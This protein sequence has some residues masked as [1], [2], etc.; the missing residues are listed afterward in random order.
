MQDR[1]L[2]RD[3]LSDL[4]SVTDRRGAHLAKQGGAYEINRRRN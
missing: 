1:A 4:N 2:L 3:I